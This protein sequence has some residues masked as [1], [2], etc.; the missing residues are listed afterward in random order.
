MSANNNNSSR[1]SVRGSIIC[2][3]SSISGSKGKL[4]LDSSLIKPEVDM[5]GKQ[6][7]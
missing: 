7:V 3:D 5:F 4:N 6:G 2:A 1:S